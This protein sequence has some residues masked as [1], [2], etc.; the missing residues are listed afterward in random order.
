MPN[1]EDEEESEIQRTVVDQREHSEIVRS[2]YF[3]RS[4]VQ[5]MQ[6]TTKVTS[7]FQSRLWWKGKQFTACIFDATEAAKSRTEEA[8]SLVVAVNTDQFDRVLLET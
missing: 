1:G 7:D 2:V 5:R 6:P 4:I 3:T 8:R